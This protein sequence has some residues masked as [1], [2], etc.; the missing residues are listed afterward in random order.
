MSRAEFF[1]ANTLLRLAGAFLLVGVVACTTRPAA[2]ADQ[3]GREAG[4]PETSY[5]ATFT[6]D[7]VCLPHRDTTGPQTLECAIGMKIEDGRHIALDL[8]FLPDAGIDTGQHLT[9]HG[10]FTVIEALSSDHWQ[11]Y[12]VF[13]ILSVKSI[14]E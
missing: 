10:T 2:N 8:Q 6:G 3:P 11:K 13:G 12:D 9:L 14:D 5:E 4:V 1:S 7:T